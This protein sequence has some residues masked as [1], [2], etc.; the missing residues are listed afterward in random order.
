MAAKRTA[1]K[2]TPEMVEETVEV[3]T[4]IAVQTPVAPEK[5][6][7]WMV[8]ETKLKIVICGLRSDIHAGKVLWPTAY[9]QEVIDS[10]RKQGVKLVPK[11]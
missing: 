10:L 4:P 6:V 2:K 8:A 11:E 1:K 7:I 3:E 5:P 9:S